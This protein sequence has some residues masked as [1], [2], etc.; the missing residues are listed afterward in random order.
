MNAYCNQKRSREFAHNFP[1]HKASREICVTM[2]TGRVYKATGKCRF[3]LPKKENGLP[4]IA[5]RLYAANFPELLR[6]Q[7]TD[8]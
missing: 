3:G 7:Q 5:W 6:E 2:K 8:S 4:P 1:Y